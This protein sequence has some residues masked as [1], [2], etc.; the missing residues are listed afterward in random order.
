MDCEE[1]EK[2]WRAYESSVFEHVRLCS[3][4]KLAMAS[5]ADELSCEDM[6]CDVSRA[7]QKR[8]HHRAALLRH[9]TAAGHGAPSLAVKPAI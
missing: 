2:L 6:A 8:A 1:C 5:N 7:E 9:E 4:L 3:K